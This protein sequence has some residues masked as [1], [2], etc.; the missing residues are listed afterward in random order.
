MSDDKSSTDDGVENTQAAMRASDAD[1]DQVVEI[2]R[3]AAGDGRLTS[4]EVS[5]RVEAALNARTIS[6]LARLTRDLPVS[7]VPGD[8]EKRPERPKD[9]V[10]ID[11]RWGTLHRSG[12]WE[13]PRHLDIRMHGGDV[14]LDFTEAVIGYDKLD[15]DARISIGGNLIL[16]V[17]PGIV[18]RTDDLTVGVGEVKYRNPAS[19][20]EAP[21][22]LLVNVTGR[23]KGGDVVVRHPRRKLSEWIRGDSAKSASEAQN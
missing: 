10:E 3:D 23:L 18:V 9:V 7:P 1:R 20:A 14:K 15:I 11:Q 16:V 17:R 8:P 13:V 12:T 19:D 21:V 4:D 2:L 22:E 6:E 5:E